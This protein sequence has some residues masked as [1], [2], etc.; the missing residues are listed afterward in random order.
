MAEVVLPWTQSIQYEGDLSLEERQLRDAVVKEYLFDKSWTKACKRLGMNSAMAQDYAVRFA[1]DSYVQHKL[2]QEEERIALTP[3]ANKPNE[4][5]LERE[6]VIQALKDEAYYH[7]PGSS[8]GARVSALK[9]LCAVYGMEAPRQTKL[10]V[11]VHSGVMLVPAVGTNEEWE[12][13]ARAAQEALQQE[14][15]DGLGPVH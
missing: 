12:A 10:D 6:R 2:K 8:H 9:Q 1:Q 7:G 14:T 3:A 11:G 4:L 5:A 15:L 13:A